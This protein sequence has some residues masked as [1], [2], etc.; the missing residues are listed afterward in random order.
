VVNNE[1]MRLRE[2]LFIIRGEKWNVG[3]KGSISILV[4]CGERD[5]RRGGK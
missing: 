1:R 5:F 2:Y 3:S 4:K